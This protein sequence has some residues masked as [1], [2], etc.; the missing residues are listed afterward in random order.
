M[1]A[2]DAREPVPRRRAAALRYDGGGAPTVVAAGAGSMADKIEAKAKEA[3][4][5][6]RQDPA[7]A[8]ALSRLPAGDE[9]SPD[10]YRAVAEV[11][12]WARG[13]EV[14]ARH[15]AADAS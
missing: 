2:S 3:G 13:L 1:S 9:I 8:D 12:I 14:L 10:L 5:P 6:V 7:L 11:L 15:A 4:V